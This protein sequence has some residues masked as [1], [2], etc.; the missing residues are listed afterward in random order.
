MIVQVELTD[1]E[2]KELNAYCK[3]NGLK[4]AA[5]CARWIIERVKKER[6]KENE[7]Q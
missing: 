6:E 2:A 3:A 1:K 5:T 7:N 4:K